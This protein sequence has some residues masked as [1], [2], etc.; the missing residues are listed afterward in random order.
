KIKIGQGQENRYKSGKLR[1]Y[2]DFVKQNAVPGDV[3]P[4]YVGTQFPA[5]VSIFLA[6]TYLYFSILIWQESQRRHPSPRTRWFKLLF[7]GMALLLLCYL[8]ISLIVQFVLHSY[9]AYIYYPFYLV[10]AIFT[11]WLALITYR[12]DDQAKTMGKTKVQSR[13][14]G[15]D[16]GQ[17]HHLSLLLALM[18]DQKPYQDPQLD[19]KGLAG[20]MELAPKQLSRIINQGLDQN[21]NEF[22]NQYRVQEAK[23]L[24]GD[25]QKQHLNILAL[26]YEAGFNSKASFNR[27]FR[28]FTGASPQEYR[29]KA[30]NGTQNRI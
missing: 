23:I 10:L 21:F 11:Y 9:S 28:Q 15:L 3:F 7:S 8:F 26:G 13:S 27:V 22:V 20:K 19:L 2:I 5:F 12:Q 16:L 4:I 17:R 14:L 30:L 24:L 1:S 29:Q 6:L 25:P 18:Q